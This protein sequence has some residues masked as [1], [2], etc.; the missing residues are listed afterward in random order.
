MLKKL[1][2]KI[3]RLECVNVCT[4]YTSQTGKLLKTTIKE[5]ETTKTPSY[6]VNPSINVQQV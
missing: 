2:K 1:N 3:Y 5:Q 4:F 6:M